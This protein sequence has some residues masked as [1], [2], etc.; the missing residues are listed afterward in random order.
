MLARPG[1]ELSLKA[2]TLC[3]LVFW[4]MISVANQSVA[5]LRKMRNTVDILPSASVLTGPVLVARGYLES[6][7]C[8]SCPFRDRGS[9]RV[10]WLAG[11]G[12]FWSAIQFRTHSMTR[13]GWTYLPLDGVGAESTDKGDLGNVGSSSSGRE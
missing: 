6:S 2:K 3:Q 7:A 5:A 8:H 9:T 4:P 12:L 10:V 11:A 13:T 1:C